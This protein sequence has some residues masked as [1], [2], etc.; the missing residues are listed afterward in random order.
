MKKKKS[1]KNCHKGMNKKLS[2]K[3]DI[4]KINEIMRNRKLFESR[5]LYIFEHHH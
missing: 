3:Y 1:N 5:N 2:N 4:I